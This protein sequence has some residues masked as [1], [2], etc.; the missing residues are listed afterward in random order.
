MCVCVC[1]CL[2]ALQRLMLESRSTFLA[3]DKPS[4]FKGCSLNCPLSKTWSLFSAHSSQKSNNVWHCVCMGV[5]ADA[6]ACVCLC[7]CV[8]V[9]LS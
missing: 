6:C 2:L 8:R 9:F 1:V 4:A 5:C 7:A 3:R